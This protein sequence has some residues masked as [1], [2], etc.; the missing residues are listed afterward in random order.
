MRSALLAEFGEAG[1]PYNTYY[2]DGSPIEPETAA[3]VRAAY[4][5][6]RV[7]F[8]WQRGDVMLIDNMSIYHARE[9]YTGDREV[10]V[11]MADAIVPPKLEPA[12]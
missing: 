10:L 1:L 8:P 5:A 3:V 9:S 6:E 12:G 2:G 11:A 4:E 7:S